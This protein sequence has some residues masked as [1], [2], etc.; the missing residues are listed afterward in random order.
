MM[1]PRLTP[2]QRIPDAPWRR[3]HKVTEKELFT[4]DVIVRL[5]FEHGKPPTARRTQTELGLSTISHRCRPMLSLERKGFMI[6]YTK[7]APLC[8][9]LKGCSAFT[10]RHMPRR[11]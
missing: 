4:L 5:W 10:M 6:R 1:Q 8:L 7:G 3:T 9:T 11:P 2:Y